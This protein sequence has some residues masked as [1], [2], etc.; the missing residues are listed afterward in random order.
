MTS[1]PWVSTSGTTSAL[2]PPAESGTVAIFTSNTTPGINSGTAFGSVQPATLPTVPSRALVRPSG[3]AS[4][5]VQPATSATVAMYTSNTTPGFN[6]S[7]DF[8]SGPPTIPPNVASSVWSDDPDFDRPTEPARGR[9]RRWLKK[10]GR[11]TMIVIT[12][13][14]WAPLFCCCCMCF[15]WDEIISW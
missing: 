13:P 2:F 9:K 1:R 10:A 11:N 8:G 6:A 3:T 4:A 5:L 14:L 12:A 15:D 7:T